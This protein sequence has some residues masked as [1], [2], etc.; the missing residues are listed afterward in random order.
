M[1]KAIALDDE[2]LALEIL[3]SL[4]DT[5]EY[6]EL[7]KTFTKSDEAFK[8]LKKYPV[9]LLFLDINM[10][11]ISGLDFYKKLPH[12]T[13]V[14]FTTAYSE[15]AVEG[16]T[17][18]ATDYL[19]KPI[20]LSRFQ[21][22]A[23]KAFSQ[24]KLQ[25][26]NIEQQYLFIRADYSLIKILFSD[27]LYIEGLDDYLKIHIQNQKTV[28]ARMTLKAILQKL[29]ETE[30]TR[31]HRS[32]IIPISKISKIRNKIIFIGQA[33]IPISVSY[34]EAFSKLFDQK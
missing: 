28:V 13:M 30:F 11:S 10:P 3:Q 17:L 26:Q 34:E 18:S 2:P 23:E 27:I 14:I 21:Q 4:C 19:L 22:A 1:I 20:S 33:E 29:P 32:F 5:I 6:I 9:D 16:F 24:W 25:N 12:K 31:V 15:F 8:Y 7:N